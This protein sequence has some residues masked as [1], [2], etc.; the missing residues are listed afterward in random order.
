MVS[1]MRKA[2]FLLG[3]TLDDLWL[4]TGI[5]ISKLSRLERKIYKPNQDERVK[6]A[7]A[8]KSPVGEIFPKT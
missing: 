6:I 3:L 2:R 4:K 8:L 5:N 7:K 1:N